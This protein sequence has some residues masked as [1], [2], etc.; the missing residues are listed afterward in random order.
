VANSHNVI[1]RRNR[2][3]ELWHAREAEIEELREEQQAEDAATRQLLI[4]EDNHLREKTELALKTAD[5]DSAAELVFTRAELRLK[6]D[7]VW[8]LPIMWPTWRSHLIDIFNRFPTA[9][10]G[11][12]FL[13]RYDRLRQAWT[14]FAHWYSCHR[15]FEGL[16]YEAETGRI[17]DEAFKHIPDDAHL[18]QAAALFWRRQRR[19]PRAMEICKVA[20]AKGLRDGTKSGFA[21]RLARLHKEARRVEHS[22][23]KSSP[24]SSLDER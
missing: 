23:P 5:F 11:M 4:A 13:R 12:E 7:D 18:Y 21:G 2:D 24:D 3:W 19:Y 10:H 15:R 20:I 17:Y 9:D 16:E 8:R 6:C 22:S 14:N 1:Y